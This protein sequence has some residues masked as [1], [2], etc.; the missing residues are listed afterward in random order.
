MTATLLKPQAI[1]TLTVFVEIY[2][3]DENQ[4][5]LDVDT[6]NVQF[7]IIKSNTRQRPVIERK[8]RELFGADFRVLTWECPEP[9]HEILDE[10]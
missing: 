7:E 8:V 5:P 1:E 4:D 6:I 2:Q 10:F 3:Y 9:T